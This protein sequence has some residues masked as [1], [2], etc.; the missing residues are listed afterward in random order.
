EVAG[1][2][3][4]GPAAVLFPHAMAVA[5]ARERALM[6]IVDDAEPG[7][8]EDLAVAGAEIRADHD[9][10][11]PNR[12]LGCEPSV[13]ERDVIGGIARITPLW[14]LCGLADLRGGGRDVGRRRGGGE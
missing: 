4:Q 14:R 11:L 5:E 8:A 12:W 13:L 7:V 2:E 9:G 3:R 1:V 6:P 10:V